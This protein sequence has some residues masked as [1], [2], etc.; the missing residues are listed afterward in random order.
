[1]KITF[2]GGGNMANALIGGL[3]N[4]GFAAAD[5]CAVDISPESLARLEQ[6][7]GVRTQGVADAAALACDVVVLAVKPQQA[8]AV[9][10]ALG[11]LLERQ[12]VLSI[13]AGLRIDDL[14]RWLG[15]HARLVR[16]MPN[17][18]ALIGAGIT[19]LCAAPAVSAAERDAA[20]RVL[21][22]V[23]ETLW[24]ADESQ[25]DAVTAVSGSGPA[26][27]FLLIEAMQQAASELGFS[28]DDARR[29]SVGTA[30]GAARL[31]AQSSEPASVLRERVTSK[32]GTTAAA[33]AAMAEHGVKEGIVAGVL[34]ADQR[35]RELGVEL[36]ADP[37][38][39]TPPAAG[40]P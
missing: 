25:I 5:L 24:V 11:P 34:A 3:V 6:S 29:L 37:V 26:Y 8:R 30:L 20:E 2:I 15:G 27:L 33:L 38:A 17:T 19:G 7:F 35:S 21:R 14:S 18:P 40:K 39:V 32:G 4:T 16:A 31:A 12:L 1:M 28:A 13:A 10:L 9:C 23:G 22:A 36:G